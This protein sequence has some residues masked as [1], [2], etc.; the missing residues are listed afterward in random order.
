MTEKRFEV[1]TSEKQDTIFDN[2]GS[3]DYYHLGNDTRDVKAL[4]KLLNGLHEENQQLIQLLKNQSVIIQELHSKLLEYQLKEPII[5]TR[6]YLE[7]MDGAIS[8]Y[9]HGRCGE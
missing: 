8:Y 2:E 3:D 4:C 6:E 9:T 5:L 7:T 1:G